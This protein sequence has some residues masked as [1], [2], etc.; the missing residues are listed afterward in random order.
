MTISKFPVGLPYRNPTKSYW[1]TP[2]LPIADHRTTPN[3]PSTSQYV[4]IGSGITSASIAY[5]LLA[6]EPHT[7]ILMLEARQA[8]SGATGRNGGHC[9]ACRYTSLASDLRKFG[10]EEAL[11]L[12]KFEEENVAN[13]GKLIKELGVK[14]DLREVE[15]VDIW[16]DQEE[17]DDVL[18][19][20]KKRQDVFDGKMKES[21][22]KKYKIWTRDEARKELLVPEAVGA[23]GF[24]AYALSPYK[25]V[26]GLLEILLKKGIN[27]QTNTPVVEVNQMNSGQGTAKWIVHTLERG[28]VL[29]DK[30]ILATNAYTAALYP[31]LAD[32][33]IPTRSQIAAVR[34]G[35][36]IAG[37]P[38]LKGTCVCNYILRVAVEDLE[39][40]ENS[41]FWII[42]PFIPTSP[43]FSYLQLLGILDEKI[44]EKTAKQFKNRLVLWDIP[45]IQ[46]L[47]L[48]KLRAKTDFGFVPDSMATV[49]MALTF[50]SAEALVQL[51]TGN[52][53]EVDGWLPKCYKLSR[54]PKMERNSFS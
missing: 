36:N 48:E 41:L 19:L 44:G 42:R 51:L 26:C 40:T 17:W 10:K 45:W 22:L 7:Q 1:Q 50:Q 38:A 46:S 18:E 37:N 31:P 52:E 28:Q 27:L 43:S 33:I 4:I 16:T 6:K 32:F 20:L 15:S 53:K 9:R 21:V 23:V 24:P 34:P 47:L 49:G 25:F 12:D 8:S 11:K 3:L 13:L 30:V 2:P 39:V 5:K 14:C 54:V 35:S 29:A